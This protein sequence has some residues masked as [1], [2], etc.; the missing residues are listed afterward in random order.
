MSDHPH[1]ADYVLTT[2]LAEALTEGDM[3]ADGSEV[4]SVLEA[5]TQTLT[6]R[7]PPG[8]L[9]VWVNGPQK[10]DRFPAGGRYLHL[11][12]GESVEVRTQIDREQAE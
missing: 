1:T 3:L 7:I 12:V 6:G 5:G 9:T 8:K 4:A 2:K 10:A 11:T